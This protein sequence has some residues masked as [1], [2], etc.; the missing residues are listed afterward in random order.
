[1]KRRPELVPKETLADVLTDISIPESGYPSLFAYV[2]DVERRIPFQPDGFILW[3]ALSGIYARNAVGKVSFQVGSDIT[4]AGTVLAAT[5]V[6]NLLRNPNVD[7]VSREFL[8]HIQDC[9]DTGNGLVN[10]GFITL[11]D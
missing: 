7:E 2:Q 6:A 8:F 10:A 9:I 3:R 4:K 5:E 11:S 1:M